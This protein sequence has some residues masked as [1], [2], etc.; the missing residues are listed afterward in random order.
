MPRCDGVQHP[1]R[2]A[3]SHENN[4]VNGAVSAQ[5]SPGAPGP[6]PGPES[7]SATPTPTSKGQRNRASAKAAGTRTETAVARYLAQHI[8]DRIERRAKSGS[9]DRGDIS[10]LR[11]HG[12]RVV[13]EVKSCARISVTPWLNEAEIERGNDDALAG[14]VVAKRHGKGA[15]A[16]LLVMMSLRDFVALIT[17]VRPDDD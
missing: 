14:L 2:A 6:G 10:G 5:N 4:P 9:R 13:I 15:P 16:D 1:G 7:P 17:A 8:D 11:V 12:Q 3:T